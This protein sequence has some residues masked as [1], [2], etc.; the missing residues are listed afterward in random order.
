[1]SVS[2]IS[3]W[4]GR[5]VALLGAIGGVCG[6]GVHVTGVC[7]DYAG[8]AVQ[9]TGGTVVAGGEYIEL[10]GRKIFETEDKIL[11]AFSSTIQG[12]EDDFAR[13]RGYAPMIGSYIVDE[14]RASHGDIKR[15]IDEASFRHYRESGVSEK[16]FKRVYRSV[17]L[18]ESTHNSDAL[19]KKGAVGVAQ[20]MAVNI[21]TCNLS[22]VKD[23]INPEINIDCGAKILAAAFK[24]AKGDIRGALALY[25]WGYLP[26][27]I[28]KRTGKPRVMPAETKK[29]IEDVINSMV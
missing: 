14:A 12:M 29:Y 11:T 21:E 15:W 4:V 9:W 26:G 2:A 25:N 16:E 3:I 7:L 19:S 24:A 22:S 28:D 1:M 23:L 20:I 17:V 5:K 13:S 27:S 6:A 10:G 18:N 8:Q